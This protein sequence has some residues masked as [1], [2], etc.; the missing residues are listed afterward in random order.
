MGMG[1]N[2][3]EIALTFY[4]LA[5]GFQPLLTEEAKNAMLTERESKR[6][7]AIMTFGLLT[8][9]LEAAF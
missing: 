6:W 1:L 8:F 7:F 2:G 5:N 9:I 3:V 4:Q